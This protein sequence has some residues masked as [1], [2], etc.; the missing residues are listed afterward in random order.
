LI[1]NWYLLKGYT[2]HNLL[3]EFPMKKVLR[4]SANTARWL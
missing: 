3:K 4:G 2:V 1:K